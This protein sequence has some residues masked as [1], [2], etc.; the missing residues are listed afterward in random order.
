[1]AYFNHAFKKSFLV[2]GTVTAGGTATSAL[3]A[4]KLAII[5]GSD[6]EVDT[7]ANIS[8]AGNLAYL[9]GGSYRQS[10]T[11]GNNPGH[12]GYAESI[13]SKGINLRYLHRLG[14]SKCEE[15]SA[16]TSE[17]CVASDCAPCGQNLFVRIDVKGSPAL[18]FLNHNAY[19]IGDSSGDAAANGGPLPGLCCDGQTNAGDPQTHLDPAM[20]L[21]AAMQMVLADPII[22]PFVREGVDSAAGITIDLENISGTAAAYTP[23][24]TF[25][26]VAT[27]ASAS[28][29]GATVTV[30]I[31]GAGTI[32]TITFDS[33]AG[34]ASGYVVG[35]TLTILGTALGG[36]TPANDVTFD[37]K[38]LASSGFG[39]KVT[40]S[41]SDAYYSIDQILNG[42]YT[43]STDPVDDQVSACA[44]VEGAYVETQFGDCSFDTRDFYGKEPVSIITSLLDETGDPCNDCGVVT[45]TPGLMR[46]TSGETVIRELLLTESYMQN[47]F[48]QGN[49]DSSR[50]R[51]IEGFDPILA[52]ID[53][54][55]LYKV[56]YL[57]H[58]V[59]RWNNPTGVFDNDQYLY[60]VFVKCSDTAANTAMLAMW[61]A[62]STQAD[63]MNNPVSVETDI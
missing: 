38:T 6:W 57:Q 14:V 28:G 30:V 9:V 39:I 33:A 23:S 63:A 22:K 7:I 41:G 20:A 1:M 24:T 43:A 61:N 34:A 17:I 36:A 27:S 45:N 53:R 42:G 15:G 29:T 25:T 10:D 16:A 50:I 58:S 35:E 26:A 13:K 54:S 18:R 11:I 3:G 19:A 8:N 62:I 60:Q 46:Q 52:A 5:D 56:Y 59:P 31:D 48:N 55:A 37:V 40:T 44:T 49:R 51:E 12:G 21:A 2:D 47:P 4:G 32:S